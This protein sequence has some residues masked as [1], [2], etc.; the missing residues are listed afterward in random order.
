MEAG[1][2]LSTTFNFETEVIYWRG[3]APFFYAPIPPDQ[4][5]AVRPVARAATYGWG[6][7][8]V[9]ATVGGV[10]FKTSLFPKDGTYLVPL[11][12]AVRRQIEITAGDRVAVELT[13]EGRA[14][15]QI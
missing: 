5:E 15:P 4:I 10:T 6:C 1:E 9:I 7:V 2:D 12:V 14:T 13:I 3:P 8:P 11:K